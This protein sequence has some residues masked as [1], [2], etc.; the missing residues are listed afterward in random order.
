MS[1]Y[2]YITISQIITAHR[3]QDM[4]IK[5]LPTGLGI[6]VGESGSEFPDNPHDLWATIE[7]THDPDWP[8]LFDCQICEDSC[9]LQP[10]PDLRIAILLFQNFGLSSLCRRYPFAGEFDSQ[11]P[12]YSLACID[13]KFYVV[14]TAGTKLMGPYTDGQNEFQG[15]QKIKIIRPVSVPVN[16]TK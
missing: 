16:L 12:Y 13:G 2:F 11:D 7:H 6:E 10:Y 15:D 5:E 9:G 4:L 1:D 3:M 8:C 14:S